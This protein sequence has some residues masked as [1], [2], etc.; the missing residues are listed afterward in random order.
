MELKAKQ[1]EKRQGFTIIELLTVMSIIVILFGLLVPAMTLVKTY[2]KTVKQQAQFHAIDAGLQLFHDDFGNYPISDAMD[3]QKDGTQINGNTQYPGG[4]KLAEAMLGLD[5]LGFHPW[6]VFNKDGDT[7]K[8]SDFSG[9]LYPRPAPD[10]PD[11]DPKYVENVRLRKGPYLDVTK[12]STS[13]LKAIYNAD[14]NDLVICDE[15]P[16]LTPGGSGKRVGMPVLYYKANTSNIKH[17]TKEAE[18]PTKPED[19]K[20]NIYNSMDNQSLIDLGIPWSP[21][22]YHP[23]ATNGIDKPLGFYTLTQ[24]PKIGATARPYNQDTYILM[25][26]GP[27]GLY[28]SK[29]DVFNFE[30]Q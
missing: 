24:N 30:K 26:A 17:A 5:L 19:D 12:V 21:G 27:D 25:S 4:A 13:T 18:V 22:S 16:R 9:N 23:I 29:D 3:R 2:S 11:S 14:V 28:G 20:G 1:F 6:S 8:T 10:P 15:F 7:D